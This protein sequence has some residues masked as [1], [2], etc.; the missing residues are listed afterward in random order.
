MP[1]R[2]LLR[3]VVAAFARFLGQVPLRRAFRSSVDDAA[4]GRNGM[5]G[6]EPLP[7]PEGPRAAMVG[8]LR[9]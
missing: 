7:G 1:G 5:P 9:S 8:A 6:A 3:L 2:L 4:A